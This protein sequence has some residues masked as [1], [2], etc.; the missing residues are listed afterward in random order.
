[1]TNCFYISQFGEEPREGT[2]DWQ[3]R[4]GDYLRVDGHLLHAGF[5][6]PIAMLDHYR[7]RAKEYNDLEQRKGHLMYRTLNELRTGKVGG[8]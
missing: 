6:F 3:R 1:M 2:T 8:G 7:T 5:V 4:D